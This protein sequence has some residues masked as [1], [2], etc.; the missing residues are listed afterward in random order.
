MLIRRQRKGKIS[1]HKFISPNVSVVQRSFPFVSKYDLTG[2]CEMTHQALKYNDFLR[3]VR[4]LDNDFWGI[5]IIQFE[6]K[7][8]MNFRL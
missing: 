4:P 6:Q 2:L 8:K 3:H 7:K 1:P 5:I